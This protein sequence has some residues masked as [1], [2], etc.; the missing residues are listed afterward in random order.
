M[1]A[2]PLKLTANDAEDLIVLSA[3]LQDAVTLASDITYL[4]KER[5]FAAVFS[6]FRWED[7]YGGGQ[8]RWV[9]AGVHF[10]GVLG[11]KSKDLDRSPEQVLEFLAIEATPREDGAA[12]VRLDFAGGTSISLDVECID[13]NLSDMGEPWA[14]RRLPKHPI[15]RG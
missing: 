5:R 1:A 7:H 3:C 4:P 13:V 12:E 9:K 15:D 10:N 2:A 6:R 8:K 14:G 11:V